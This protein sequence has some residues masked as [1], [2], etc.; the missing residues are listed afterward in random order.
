MNTRHDDDNVAS[1]APS[2]DAL[3]RQPAMY[4]ASL[5]FLEFLASGLWSVA[6]AGMYGSPLSGLPG[7]EHLNIVVFLLIG[8]VA[9]FVIACSMFAFPRTGAACLVVAGV[10]AIW[11]VALL[12]KWTEPVAMFFF[13][14]AP[15]LMLGI[16]QWKVAERRPF[17]FS[18]AGLIVGVTII[19]AVVVLIAELF[20]EPR[21]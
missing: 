19:A 7:D 17:R 4:A 3:R 15:M 10:L 20:R 12:P 1:A 21:P 8:P 18:L 2:G 14:P 5:G 16:W 13:V 9:F 11:R 6:G